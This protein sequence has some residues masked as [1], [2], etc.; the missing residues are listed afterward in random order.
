MHF[1]LFNLVT[2][3]SS[4]YIEV[5]ATVIFHQSTVICLTVWNC[6]SETA[7]LQPDITVLIS[8]FQHPTDMVYRSTL[9]LLRGEV[10]TG[11]DTG[12]VYLCREA[13]PEAAVEEGWV[14]GRTRS[15]VEVRSTESWKVEVQWMTTVLN[16]RQIPALAANTC[17]ALKNNY[18]KE[19]KATGWMATV[20]LFIADP[21]PSWLESA[22]CCAFL[23]LG[24]SPLLL[25]GSIPSRE[26]K[27][28]RIHTLLLFRKVLYFRLAITKHFSRNL[29]FIPARIRAQI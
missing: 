23:H 4:D 11:K 12:D 27:A 20:Q 8:L 28:S 15:T 16:R 10:L 25:P 19:A 29:L 1:P 18:M 14:E 24:L 17:Q 7:D 13:H 3:W 22:H 2:S 21:C 6:L 26:P 5:W 9:Q